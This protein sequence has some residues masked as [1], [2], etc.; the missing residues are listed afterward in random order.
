M[1]YS[2]GAPAKVVK[3]SS[4]KQ[5]GCPTS[6]FVYTSTLEDGSNLPTVIAF[7]PVDRKYSISC[8]STL[9]ASTFIIELVGTLN[10]FSLLF[11][12]ITFQVKIEDP[13][14]NKVNAPPFFAMKL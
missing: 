4:F 13:Y 11:K 6:A 5:S 12:K 7:D 9:C 10:G 14:A 3:F 8:T 1:V 2:I